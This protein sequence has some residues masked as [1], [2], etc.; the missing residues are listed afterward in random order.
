[1]R[2][3]V[4]ERIKMLSNSK[5][6]RISCLFYLKFHFFYSARRKS[7]KRTTDTLNWRQPSASA[8]YIHGN[9]WRFDVKDTR[10]KHNMVWNACKGFDEANGRIS[11]CIDVS[12]LTEMHSNTVAQQWKTLVYKYQ[13]VHI[14]SFHFY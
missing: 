5:I 12:T 3:A 6:F 4:N 10:Q 13:T 9:W 8:C 1:M 11:T 7:N 14:A 2:C